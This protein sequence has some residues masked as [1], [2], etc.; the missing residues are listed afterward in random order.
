MTPTPPLP[1][2]VVGLGAVGSR[3][4]RQ[5][6][7]SGH[8][9]IAHD[10]ES[11]AFTTLRG[12]EQCTFSETIDAF[13][14]TSCCSIVLCTP[15]PQASLATTFLDRGLDVVAVSDD[16]DDVHE[17][18]ALDQRARER[19]TRLIV[20]AAAS[21]GMSGLLAAELALR[22]DTVDEIHVAFHGTGGPSCARQHHQALGGEALGWHDD[23]WIERPGGSG[24]ELL[25]F[26]EPVGGKDCYRA[27]LA[28]PIVLKRAFPEVSRI[29]AR[30]SATRRDRLTAR[31]PMMSPPH[32]EGG[33][34]GLRVEVRGSRD[35]QR[36]TE[37]AGIA[38]RTAV[39]AASV[40]ASV[41]DHLSRRER[42]QSGVIT[43]GDGQ[44]DDVSLVTAVIERD[45]RVF[46]YVGVS[47]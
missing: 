15:A 1:I 38:E 12:V 3:V 17:L 5:L 44:L 11:T 43:L 28:D 24:R 35:G 14:D 40:A 19:G 6:I 16:A 41:A 13:S 23:E 36:V 21:P 29:S 2:G 46:E 34:G 47:D 27:E 10:V 42:D 31:L 20:G 32:A 25:W 22:F 33:L 8:S 39:I 30:V 45:I 9:V 18:V 4:A 7:E 37:V 26:P